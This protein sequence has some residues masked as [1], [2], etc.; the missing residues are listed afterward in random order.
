M[1]PCRSRSAVAWCLHLSCWRGARAA[2]LTVSASASHSFH[3]PLQIME[4]GPKVAMLPVVDD[5]KVQGL[6]TLHGLVSA[7]L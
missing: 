6:I 3:C 2:L 4:R 5:G 7:G 1:L